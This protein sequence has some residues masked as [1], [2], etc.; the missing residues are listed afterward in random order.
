MP[1]RDPVVRRTI[2]K[3]L[4]T[5]QG[6]SVATSVDGSISVSI[7]V[8]R[9]GSDFAKEVRLA[10]EALG[11]APTVAI[12]GRSVCVTTPE[13]LEQAKE[14]RGVHGASS[15]MFIRPS[16]PK[17]AVSPAEPIDALLR[18]PAAMSYH[19][20]QPGQ[21]L[22]TSAGVISELPWVQALRP[23]R[24]PYAAQLSDHSDLMVW[25]I[26]VEFE[27]WPIP[28]ELE[29]RWLTQ[30]TNAEETWRKRPLVVGEDS[31]CEYSCGEVELAARLRVAGFHAFWISE[32]SGF[33]HVRCW[34]P[35]CVKR[36]ELTRRAPG[37]SAQDEQL[38]AKASELG[39]VLGSSGGHPDIA[40]WRDGSSSF[41]YME[42]KGPGDDIK[43]KQNGWATAI[44]TSESSTTPYIAVKGM[45]RG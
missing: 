11:Y 34:E 15:A 31:G 1:K 39:I 14:G 5:A 2:S 42:Y 18:R 37:V 27:R 33:L 41:F 45:I 44:L 40:A 6:W 19:T 4:Q 13:T 22:Q 36:S 32:W 28:R 17:L 24:E 12:K 20:P 26:D 10:V 23:T 43:L 8:A 38:R 7:P 16:F 21:I 35:F 29:E 25:H 9:T 30:A 3:S